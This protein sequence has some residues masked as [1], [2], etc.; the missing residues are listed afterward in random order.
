VQVRARTE[1]LGFSAQKARLV[2][3]Q[4]RGKP[5]DEA[6][7]LLRFTPTPIARSIAKVLRSAAANAE[8]NYQLNP[9]GLTVA[10]IMADEGPL[11]ERFR[12]DARSRVAPILRRSC[13]ITVIVEGESGA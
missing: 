8:N 9:R 4:V 6:L 11:L 7:A 13:H 5:V 1:A 10:Q 12:P 3:D 2:V